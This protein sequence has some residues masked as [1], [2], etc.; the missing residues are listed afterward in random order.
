MT[1]ISLIPLLTVGLVVCGAQSAV[2][3]TTT[4]SQRP[5]EGQ[6]SIP[7]PATQD[8]QFPFPVAPTGI[9]PEAMARMRAESPRYTVDPS[10]ES[11]DFVRPPDQQ[12]EFEK[13]SGLLTKLQPVPPERIAYFAWLESPDSPIRF[14]SW[15]CLVRQ[16]KPIPGGWAV[17]LQAMARAEDPSG[18][19]YDVLRRFIEEYTLTHTGELRYVRGYPHPEDNDNVPKYKRFGGI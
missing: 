3:Q 17:T 5:V 8:K 11:P 19:P 12:K 9:S 7:L 18:H 2:S 13:V 14:R 10:R 1:K 4:A 15:G 16:A 6:V